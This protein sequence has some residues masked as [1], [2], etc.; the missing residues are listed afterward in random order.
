MTGHGWL[1]VSVCVASVAELG[2]GLYMV[3]RLP[4]HRGRARVLVPGRVLCWHHWDRIQRNQL[5][6][7]TTFLRIRC[8]QTR[9]GRVVEYRRRRPA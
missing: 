2:L 7:V 4:L 9:C 3:R 5:G 6:D 8:R 1:I